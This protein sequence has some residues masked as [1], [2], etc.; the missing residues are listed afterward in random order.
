MKKALLATVAVLLAAATLRPADPPRPPAKSADEPPA[1]HRLGGGFKGHPIGPAEKGGAAA[2][3]AP[4]SDK[5]KPRLMID[6]ALV[7]KG[8][9][10]EE[11]GAR[12][13]APAPPP[14]AAPPP[15]VTMPKIVDLQGH[16]EAYWRAKAAA[17]RD[18]VQKAREAVAAAEAEEKREEN[19]FYAW[20][21]GQYRDNV[22]KPAWDR[23]KE[24]T[25]KTRADLEAA[26]KDLDQ[27]ED[28]AR[29]AGAFPGWIR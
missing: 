13:A 10:P 26:Q 23:A 7:K 5:K 21:D 28:E 4:P 19:D 11:K 20:D 18:A 2:K 17:V 3:P 29:R 27:L 9:P 1:R 22:I 14:A 8:E 6:N 16:D 12:K 24:Q 15:P 25:V